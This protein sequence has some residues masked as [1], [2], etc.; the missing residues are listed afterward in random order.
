VVR[1]G[2]V[3]GFGADGIIRSG[4]VHDH[5]KQLQLDEVYAVLRALKAGAIGEDA[6]LQRLERS[7]SWV[8]TARDPPST[9]LLGI[10]GG[11]R[12]WAMAQRVVHQVV[13]RLTPG[14]VPLCLTDGLTDYSPA[15]LTHVGPWRQPA[16]RRDKGPLPKPRWVPVPE[17]LDAQ[18]VQ[19]YRRQRLVGV[20]YRGVF[21]TMERVPQVLSVCGRTLNT[22]FIARLNLDIRQRVAAGGRRVTT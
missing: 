11:T 21:G 15:G 16:R 18:V 17:R 19:S 4:E 22:A 3:P 10:D 6:A 5:V 12:T 7:P 8:W 20:T 1:W 9:L 2:I 14:C 13:E